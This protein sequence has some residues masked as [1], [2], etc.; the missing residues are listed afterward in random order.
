MQ[1]RPEKRWTEVR[2]FVARCHT[3]DTVYSLSSVL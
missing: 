2:L 1:R 3:L